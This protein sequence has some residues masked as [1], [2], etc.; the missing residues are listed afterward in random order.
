[1][2]IAIFDIS[3]NKKLVTTSLLMAD[4]YQTTT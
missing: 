1:V 2:M 3:H 4:H